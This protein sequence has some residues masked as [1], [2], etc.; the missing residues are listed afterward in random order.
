M[1]SFE[2]LVGAHLRRICTVSGAFDPYMHVTFAKKGA[3]FIREILARSV[4]LRT[5]LPCTSSCLARPTA[6]SDYDLPWRW[7]PSCHG[8]P[9]VAP[10]FDPWTQRRSFAACHSLLVYELRSWAVQPSGCFRMPSG[11]ECSFRRSLFYGTG[12]LNAA[13]QDTG[14]LN[15]ARSS[16]ALPAF[17]SP[18]ATK[19]TGVL[20]AAVRPRLCQRSFRRSQLEK[21]AF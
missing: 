17:V 5:W 15:A 20:N 16:G 7:R 19:E 3:K 9:A 21:P 11:S 1:C 6:A 12:V 8:R 14:D 4:A 18:I 10:V 2:S 13:A